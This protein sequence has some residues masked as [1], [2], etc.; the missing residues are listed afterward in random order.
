MTEET[1]INGGFDIIRTSKCWGQIINF[2]DK[3]PKNSRKGSLKLQKV[4]NGAKDASTE[5]IEATR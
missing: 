4:K 3:L 2:F 5:L 1:V